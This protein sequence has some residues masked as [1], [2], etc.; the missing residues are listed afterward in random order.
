MPSGFTSM[1]PG[2][3]RACKVAAASAE[4][5]DVPSPW[6]EFVQ[7]I[8]VPSPC[9]L[10]VSAWLGVRSAAVGGASGRGSPDTAGMGWRATGR[11][12][13]R[14]GMAGGGLEAVED[15]GG[16]AGVEDCG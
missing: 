3:R 15:W 9:P 5:A 10:L 1:S 4:K 13:E 14:E 6:N 2:S 12:A 7:S 16:E 11:A 8:G